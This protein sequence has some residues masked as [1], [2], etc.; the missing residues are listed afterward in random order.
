MLRPGQLDRDHRLGASLIE[1][2]D[3]ATRVLG[4]NVGVLVA[5]SDEDRWRVALGGS[6][7]FSTEAFL[8]ELR[9]RDPATTS[10][11]PWC[12]A[13]SGM[14]SPSNSPSGRPYRGCGGQAGGSGPSRRLALITSAS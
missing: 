13:A 11:S 7:L 9:R 10:P 5:V 2:I 12:V 8:G 1:G 14:R 4:R 3:K 6:E